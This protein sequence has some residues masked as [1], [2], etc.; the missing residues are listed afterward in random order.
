M[1]GPVLIE[2]NLHWGIPTDV[3]LGDTDY[4]DY[5][6]QPSPAGRLRA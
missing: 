4:I 3:P 2:A 5:L 1:D 6:F